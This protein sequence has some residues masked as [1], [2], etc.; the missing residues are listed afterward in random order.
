M[1]SLAASQGIPIPTE[2]I[3]SALES[4]AIPGFTGT[5]QLEI[6]LRPEAASCVMIGVIRRHSHRGE[7][8]TVTRQELPDPSRKKPVDKVIEEIK[9]RLFIRTVVTAVEAHYL[10]GVLQNWTHQE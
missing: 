5:M 2:E 7:Q 10:N 1:P 9:N 6:G 8:Q 3:R 4:A